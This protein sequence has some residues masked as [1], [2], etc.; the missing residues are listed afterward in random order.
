MSKECFVTGRKSRSG[1]NRSHAMNYTKRTFKPNL[2]KVRILVDGTHYLKGMA[3]YSDDMPKGVDVVFNTNKS[4]ST[5]LQ[6]VLK[7]ITNDP[8]NPFGALI[9]ETSKGGQYWYDDKNGNKKLGLINKKSDEGD[10]SDWKDVLPSQFLSKQ[11]LS[12]VKKQLNL[13]KVD[14]QTE[15]DD[16]CSLTNPTVKRHYLQ[17]FADKCDGAAVNLQAAALPGQKYHVIIPVNTLKDTEVYAPQYKDGSKLALVRY[18]H[19]GTFDRPG[20]CP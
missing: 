15:F 3:V 18:P 10:W 19:G 7:P 8:D 20:Y 11:P 17:E 12:L 14:K 1:N 16:I 13:A 4:K 9:K 5:P 6:K 2:Q